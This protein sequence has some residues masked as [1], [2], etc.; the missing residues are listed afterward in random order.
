MSL[1]VSTL[2][3]VE[4]T[5]EVRLVWRLRGGSGVFVRSGRVAFCLSVGVFGASSEEE[6]CRRL[7]CRRQAI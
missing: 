2:S 1:Q 6:K 5:I 4:T 7:H 3:S